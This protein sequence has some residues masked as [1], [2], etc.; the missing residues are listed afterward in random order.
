M[1]ATQPRQACPGI[2]HRLRKCRLGACELTEPRG[3]ELLL[4]PASVSPGLMKALKLTAVRT[5][6]RWAG[7]VAATTKKAPCRHHAGA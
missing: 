5:T 4:K 3:W 1:E 6:W 2:H 7:L